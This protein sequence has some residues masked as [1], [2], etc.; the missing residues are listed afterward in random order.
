M[1]TATEQAYVD[2]GLQAISLEISEWRFFQN[3]FT[4]W[5]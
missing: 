2:K 3:R 1:L 5:W 4:F